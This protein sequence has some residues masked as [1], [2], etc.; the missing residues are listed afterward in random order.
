MKQL[1]TTLLFYYTQHIPHVPVCSAA[2][3]CTE[4]CLRPP[5]FCLLASSK[6]PFSIAVIAHYSFSDREIPL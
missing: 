2:K 5:A 1:T 6:L 4:P 3:R